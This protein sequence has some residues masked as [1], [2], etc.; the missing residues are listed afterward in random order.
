[1]L[2]YVEKQYRIED[3]LPGMILGEDISDC[4]GKIIL[5]QG[6]TLSER[7]IR[8]LENWNIAKVKIREGFVEEIADY[9]IQSFDK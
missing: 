9:Y 4:S 2:R 7:L 6:V 8:L 3:V 5:S 1:M